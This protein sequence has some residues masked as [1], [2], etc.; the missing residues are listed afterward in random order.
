[1]ISDD[2]WVGTTSIINLSEVAAIFGISLR[3][4][5]VTWYSR[6]QRFGIVTES[7][8]QT[9]EREKEQK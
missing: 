8:S 4:P 9:D 5:D 3:L 2:F 1:M 6:S 7:L